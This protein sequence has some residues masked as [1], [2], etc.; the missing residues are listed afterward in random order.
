[1]CTLSCIAVKKNPTILMCFTCFQGQ[2]D[3]GGDLRLIFHD[4]PLCYLSTLLFF[5]VPEILSDTNTHV[6]PILI[7][8]ATGPTHT[9]AHAFSDIMKNEMAPVHSA[10]L[11]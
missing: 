10:D 6:I 7:F 3:A 11:S 9:S 5:Q 4:T 8:N 1:M 2:R